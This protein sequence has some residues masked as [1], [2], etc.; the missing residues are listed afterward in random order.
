MSDEVV[1]VVDAPNKLGR[2]ARDVAEWG[3]PF[4]KYLRKS[5]NISRSARKARVSPTTA[6]KHARAHPGFRAA[7]VRAL[8]EYGDSLEENLGV[9]AFK[10]NVIANIA[11]LKGLNDRLAARYSEKVTDNRV[12]NLTLNQAEAPVS[13]EAAAAQL[14]RLIAQASPQTLALL[15][16]R[17]AQE[18]ASEVLEGEVVPR[19]GGTP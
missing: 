7:I 2:P 18:P 10:G 14:Q 16:G 19:G 12:L 13:L 9:L 8:R 3:P 4:L 5:G 17:P 11:R 6:R 15:A 1:D